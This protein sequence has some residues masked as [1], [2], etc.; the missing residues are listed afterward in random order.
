MLEHIVHQGPQRECQLF[1][2]QYGALKQSYNNK[3][4]EG[5][6]SLN[7]THKHL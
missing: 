4:A 7:P 5:D 6:R 3:P 2:L 1:E